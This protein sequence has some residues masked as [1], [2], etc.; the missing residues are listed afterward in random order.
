MD[1]LGA[2]AAFGPQIS[3]SCRTFD[4]TR[5]FEESFFAIAPSAI[6]IAFAAFRTWRISSEKPIVNRGWLYTAKLVRFAHSRKS[7]GKLRVGLELT[8]L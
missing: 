2:D 6:F 7:F 5:T 8:V 3:P 4:F 1:C